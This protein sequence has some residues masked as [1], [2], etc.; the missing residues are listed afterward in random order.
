MNRG[1][2]LRVTYNV[3]LIAAEE[4][5]RTFYCKSRVKEISVGKRDEMIEKVIED[6]EVV[7]EWSVDI[8]GSKLLKC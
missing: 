7:L 2:L 6:E 4:V 5:V 3:Y 1:G 8:I